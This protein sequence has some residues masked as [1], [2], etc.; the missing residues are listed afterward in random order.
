MVSEE[1]SRTKQKYPASIFRCGI[2]FFALPVFF[3]RLS[4]VSE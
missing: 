1:Y 4:K 2:F 3:A